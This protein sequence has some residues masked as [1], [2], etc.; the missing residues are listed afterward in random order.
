VKRL[1]AFALALTASP[2][3]AQ[4]MDLTV[5]GG[6][7]T[8]ANIDKKTEGIEDLKVKGSFTWG[9][10]LDRDLSDHLGAEISWA[11]QRSA[12]TIG[13]A[14]GS[15]DLF[16]MQVGRLHGNV[17][18]RFGA[19]G[20]NVKPFLFAGL[21]GAFLTSRDVGTETKLSWGLGAGL[22]WAPSKNWGARLQARYTQVQL[23]DSSSDVCDP[24]GFCQ[25]SLRQVEL[26]AGLALRF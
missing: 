1:A 18:Y 25:G 23:S 14:S 21:G 3:F 5:L 26:L 17:L 20:A 7:S 12:L 13:T 4:H 10:E 11:Q 24:F 19:P 22:K 9:L 6:Y 15:A 2:A 8:A 16:D